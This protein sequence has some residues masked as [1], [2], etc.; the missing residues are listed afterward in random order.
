LQ[1]SVLVVDECADSS[2]R[3]GFS[4][5]RRSSSS[6]APAPAVEA[7]V[8]RLCISANGSGCSCLRLAVGS[9]CP[10]CMLVSYPPRHKR[11][12]V[13]HR[14]GRRAESAAG[15]TKVAGLQRG[16]PVGDCPAGLL[17]GAPARRTDRLLAPRKLTASRRVSYLGAGRVRRRRAVQGARRCARLIGCRRMRYVHRPPDQADQAAPRLVA[18]PYGSL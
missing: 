8:E 14:T 9:S 10:G 5:S 1:R 15:R 16:P 3:H 4:I 12:P 6:S 11:P 2:S 7:E 17:P 13:K 18:T